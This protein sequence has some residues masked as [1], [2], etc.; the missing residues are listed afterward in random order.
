MVSLNLAHSVYTIRLPL[1][2]IASVVM[3]TIVAKFSYKRKRCVG[4]LITP[5]SDV[6][7]FQIL[8]RDWNLKP[9]FHSKMSVCR[10]ELATEGL[11]W[12]LNPPAIPTLGERHLSTTPSSHWSTVSTWTFVGPTSHKDAL[13]HVVALIFQHR[14][15]EWINHPSHN[16]LC[17]FMSTLFRVW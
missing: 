8:L 16:R 2:I 5:G 4:I 1:R 7:M 10:Q 3:L 13:I 17:D 14:V 12:T 15:Y 11:D 9:N 6:E